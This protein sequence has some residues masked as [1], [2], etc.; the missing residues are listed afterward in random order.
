MA[1]VATPGNVSTVAGDCTCSD[2]DGSYGLSTG[3]VIVGYTAEEFNLTYSPGYGWT[4]AKDGTFVCTWFSDAFITNGS[5][6]DIGATCTLGN[7]SSGLSFSQVFVVL[8]TDDKWRMCFS[9]LYY[10]ADSVD[11]YTCYLAGEELL[12]GSS[13]NPVDCGSVGEPSPTFILTINLTKF[14]ESGTSP[15][16]LECDP[17]TQV[18]IEGNP[19]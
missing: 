16:P 12:D 18:V 8:G 2:L 7:Y 5:T 19:Q 13:G 9:V 1:W 15:T 3:G 10:D 6:V 17:P 14:F 4:E 11:T